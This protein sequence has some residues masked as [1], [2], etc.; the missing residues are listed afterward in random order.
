MESAKRLKTSIDYK[1]EKERK[2]LLAKKEF[3][4]TDKGIILKKIIKEFYAWNEKG[5][6]EKQADYEERLKLDSKNKFDEICIKEL[7]H[8]GLKVHRFGKD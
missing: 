4:K 7:N 3:E 5:E 6:F 8:Y 1:R 2:A